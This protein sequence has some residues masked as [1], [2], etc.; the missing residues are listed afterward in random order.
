M[1]KNNLNILWRLNARI[2]NELFFLLKKIQ[3]LLFHNKKMKIQFSI[4]QGWKNDIE[5]GFQ[6]TRHEIVFEEFSAC[7]IKNYDLVVPLTI[8]DLKILNKI[9][10]LIIGNP[11]PIPNIE[12]IL[13]CDNKY[14]FY[15]TLIKNGFE[16]AIPKMEGTIE[17]PYI[18]KKI[19][20]EW[21]VNCHVIYDTKDEQ[22][23]SE[24]ITHQ[25]YI[26]QE[27]VIGSSEYATHILFKDQKIINSLNIK[28][29][30]ET[31]TPIKGKDKA[32]YKKI[33]H[34]QYLDLF[35]S[36]LKSINFDGLCCINYKIHNNRPII[37]EINPRFGGSL[38]QYFFSFLNHIN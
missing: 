11:I 10:H 21:G 26:T 34:C 17:F 33:C 25:D 8:P 24:I 6:F 36:I 35:S 27:L 2:T 23:F 5:K 38:S 18:L 32:L 7:S 16:K 9:R 28:Y 14:L 19:I 31:E 13:I 1:M 29:V 3:Y 12:S 30:F 20:D 37:L 22:S 4:Q 15:Q